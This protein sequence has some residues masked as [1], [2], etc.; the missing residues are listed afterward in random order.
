ML[1]GSDGS[2]GKPVAYWHVRDVLKGDKDLKGKVV[3][4][5]GSAP[6]IRDARSTMISLTGS[7]DCAQFA[8]QQEIGGDSISRSIQKPESCQAQL[9]VVNRVLSGLATD[10]DADNDCEAFS[11]HPNACERPH[12]YSKRAKTAL[13]PWWPALATRARQAC[14]AEWSRQPACAPVVMP[15]HCHEHVCV[16]GPAIGASPLARASIS[17]S[18]SPTDGS[19]T[20]I[21]FRP[22]GVDYPQLSVNWWSGDRPQRGAAGTFDIQGSTGSSGLGATYCAAERACQPLRAVKLHLEVGADG[23]G[24]VELEGETPSGEKLRANVPA[25]FAPFKRVFCG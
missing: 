19:A 17:E 21:S 2:C 25:E 22:Q 23:K 1:H 18:C 3:A 15:A 11:L 6:P 10:C 7:A 4:I 24:K 8:W 9:E 12:P 5:Y 20:S 13:P 14:S 16:E